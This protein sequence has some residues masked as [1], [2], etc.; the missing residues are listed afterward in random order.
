MKIMIDKIMIECLNDAY[1][2]D[3]TYASFKKFYIEVVKEVRLKHPD[4]I[5]RKKENADIADFISNYLSKQNND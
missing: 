2:L 3:L 1:G 5:K 4:Y